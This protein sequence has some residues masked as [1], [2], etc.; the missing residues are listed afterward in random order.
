MIHR[1]HVL[2][3]IAALAGSGAARAELSPAERA[4]IER[5]IRYVESRKDVR[6]VRNGTDYSCDD[7][8]KFLRKKLDSMG[9]HVN[10]AHEFIDQ[11][12]SKSSTSGQPYTIRFASGLI[13]PAAKFLQ[14]ELKR[15]DAGK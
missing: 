12:A 7:A 14:D 6:F 13:E 3:L 15:M 4:R 5:L 2:C 1:R 8:A 10:T 9:E 11:I